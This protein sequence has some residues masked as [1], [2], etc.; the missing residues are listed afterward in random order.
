MPRTA[1]NQTNFTAGEVSPRIFG[2][3]DL[4]KY[5]NGA[6]LLENSMILMHGGAM[7]RSGT[8]FVKE[9]K[10]S[11]KTTRLKNFE[12]ST[13]QSYILELGDQYIRFFKDRGQIESTKTISGAANNGSGLVRITATAHGYSTGNTVT[14]SGVVGTTEANG[15]HVITVISV[16][17]FDLVGSS[18]SNA[19]TSGGSAVAIV[20]IPTSYLEAEIFDLRFAQSADTLFTV[21]ENHEPAKLTRTSH[22]DWSI[23]DIEFQD[24]PFLELNTTATT[25]GLSATTG[26]VTVTASAVVGINSGDGFKTTDVGRLIR[27]KD[28][29]G[30]FT[31]LK[32]TAFTDTTHVT[33]TINGPDASATTATVDWRLGAWSATTGFPSLVTFFEDR[34][35]FFASTDNPQTIWASKASDFENFAPTDAG[36]TVADD[37][38]ITFTLGTDQVNKVVWVSSGK[39]LALGT[40]GGEFTVGSSSSSGSVTPTDIQVLRETT[41]GSSGIEPVRVGPSVLFVTRHRKKVH[42][43]AYR[44]D[45][46]QFQAPEMTLLADHIAQKK[47]KETAFS[48]EPNSIYWAV[49]DNGHLIGMTYERAQE[50]IG[51]H[52]HLIGGT[53]SSDSFAHCESVAVIPGDD[54]DE[55]YL[56]CKRT[57]NGAQKRYI[58]FIEDEFLPET[59]TSADTAFFVD[60]GATFNQP[61]T[62]SAATQADPVVVTATGHG[63]SNG[64]TVRIKSVFGMTELNNKRFFVMSSATNTVQLTATDNP[65]GITAATQANPCVVTSAGHGLVNGEKI[66]ILDVEGMTQLNG[67]IYTVANKT[68]NTFELTGINSTGFG[69]YTAAG[70]IYHAIDSTAFTPYL[71]G[72]ELHLLVSTITGL[73]HLEGQ[74]IQ[75]VGDG[76]VQPTKTV[77]SGAVTLET[78]AAVIHLG[79]GYTTKIETLRP[80][81]GSAE[82][83][84]QGKPKRIFEVIY[85]FHETLGAQFGSDLDDLDEILFRKATDVMDAVPPL[86]SGDK[87][88]EFPGDWDTDGKQ[89]IIQEQPYP[90]T[91]LSVISRMLVSDG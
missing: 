5:A 13:Y 83:T 41:Q 30:N 26:S 42:E 31:W 75:I 45:Y 86:F 48:I 57:I 81:A 4:K 50:V 19:Y 77:S 66:G 25:L 49:L 59:A 55:V 17:T 53:F 82:G 24:G 34:L 85:R 18:F 16:N 67:L 63:L 8:R 52:R 27:W 1:Y 54:Q 35:W 78:P 46:D 87:I 70:S 80:E 37:S 33:A 62:I 61:I 10:D 91:L 9:V 32:I 89:F 56:I 3:V 65:K 39:K 44:F 69:A 58:E 90:L 71:S 20:E 74:T 7:R 68:D 15:T 72:G 84:S 28:A 64:N 73:G 43:F 14:I 23:N 76:S 2:R 29:A 47:I 6:S 38:A 22:T 40:P 51:W 88:E 11:S 21:R 60:S 79:L 36:G 12:F